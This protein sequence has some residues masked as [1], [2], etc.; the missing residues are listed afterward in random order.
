MFQQMKR[1][2]VHHAEHGDV[3]HYGC[4]FA[5]GLDIADF[6]VCLKDGAFAL[7]IP[8][9]VPGGPLVADKMNKQTVNE[10]L[11]AFNI[12]EFPNDMLKR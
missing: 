9:R 2:I 11:K 3:A 5:S 6:T 12:P 4:N 1:W 8:N 7:L 10:I